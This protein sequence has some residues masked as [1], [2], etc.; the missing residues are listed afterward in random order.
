LNFVAVD[1]YLQHK[2]VCR[3]INL[4]VMR[5]MIW[6]GYKMCYCLDHDL[7]N[8]IVK[9]FCF[10]P[11][12]SDFAEKAAKFFYTMIMR[13]FSNIK[14]SGFQVLFEIQTIFF[15]FETLAFIWNLDKFVQILIGT[16]PLQNKLLSG[17]QTVKIFPLGWTVL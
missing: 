7:T 12:F 13:K 4:S 17:F 1:W 2:E 6:L 15:R 10:K 5:V 14:W 11:S 3:Q 9:V 8:R 16:N